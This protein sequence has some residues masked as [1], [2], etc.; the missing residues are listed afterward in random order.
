[1]VAV[2]CWRGL[3]AVWRVVAG[4]WRPLLLLL[5][6]IL[7]VLRKLMEVVLL[8]LR[9]CRLPKWHV[10]GKRRGGGALEP[11]RVEDLCWRV[12][13]RGAYLRQVACAVDGR[14]LD[15][16]ERHHRLLGYRADRR[17]RRPRLG[18]RPRWWL[19]RQRRR[20]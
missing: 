1:M 10:H 14:R 11:P 15:R 7:V 20:Q 8:L 3:V 13:E 2:H 18:S 17:R 16:V 9:W 5:L 19:A 12:A 4:G 6:L